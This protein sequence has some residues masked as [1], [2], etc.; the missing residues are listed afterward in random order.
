VPKIKKKK[1]KIKIQAP[2]E[3]ESAPILQDESK[4]SKKVEQPQTTLPPGDV[5]KVKKPR[6]PKKKKVVIM[7][8]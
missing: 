7:D 5:I 3:K 2:K 8:D 4:I 6:K 1:K